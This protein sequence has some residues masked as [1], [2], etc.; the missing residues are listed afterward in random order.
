MLEE[1]AMEQSGSTPTLA[2]A[3]LGRPGGGRPSLT[4]GRGV[5]AVKALSARGDRAAERPPPRSPR[6]APWVPLCCARPATWPGLPRPAGTVRSA[7]GGGGLLGP[8]RFGRL[9]PVSAP[10][11]RR[12][13]ELGRV[14]G[15]GLFAPPPPR[16]PAREEDGRAPALRPVGP[17]TPRCV[18]QRIPAL[19][20]FKANW[21]DRKKRKWYLAPDTSV[22]A[23]EGGAETV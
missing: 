1:T 3:S 5:S 8:L 12:V 15:R 6:P 17:C 11:A 14:A 16:A 20:C 21:G 10:S 22:T 18:S 4:R 13:S 2:A 7:P 9:G 23:W 19:L